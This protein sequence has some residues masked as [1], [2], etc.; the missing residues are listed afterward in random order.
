MIERDD[1]H[2]WGSAEPYA[3]RHSI[4]HTTESPRSSS[5]SRMWLL[6]SSVGYGGT[7]DHGVQA[8]LPSQGRI[9]RQWGFPDVLWRGASHSSTPG[10]IQKFL[11]ASSRIQPAVFRFPPR[12]SGSGCPGMRQ[13]SSSCTNPM[14][15]G[16]R[17]LSKRH[18][19]SFDG[20]APDPVL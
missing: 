1:Q 14:P 15:Q 17:G 10:S 4:F 9:E 18:T 19:V 16:T 8:G 5:S 7:R 20:L 11:S 12:Q 13:P 6:T 2:S 3:D